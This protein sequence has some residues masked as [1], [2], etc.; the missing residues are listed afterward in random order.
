MY[1]TVFHGCRIDPR[2]KGRAYACIIIACCVFAFEGAVVS[3][4]YSMRS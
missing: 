3:D 2:R 4:R 1:G